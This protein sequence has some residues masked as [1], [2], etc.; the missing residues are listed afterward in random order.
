MPGAEDQTTYERIFEREIYY[1]N[2][3]YVRRGYTV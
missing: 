3:A 1:F 2:T